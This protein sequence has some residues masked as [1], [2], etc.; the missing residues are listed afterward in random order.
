MNAVVYG[1]KVI[2]GVTARGNPSC[3]VVRQSGSEEARVYGL[4]VDSLLFDT[5]DLLHV[6]SVHELL[7]GL[8]HKDEVTL[9]VGVRE[10]HLLAHEPAD[11]VS[12]NAVGAGKTQ[13][14]AAPVLSVEAED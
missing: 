13:L 5:V 4:T 3:L 7:Q 6:G 10:M 12:A 11:S 8:V 1:H 14:R 9:V 2:I